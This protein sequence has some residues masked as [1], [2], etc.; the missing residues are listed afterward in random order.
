MDVIKT[1]RP[2]D[3]GTKKLT[4]RYGDKLVCVRYRKDQVTQRRYTTIELIVDEGPI[5]AAE[6]DEIADETL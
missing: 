4:K 5:G 1:L 2:G 6:R 3:S